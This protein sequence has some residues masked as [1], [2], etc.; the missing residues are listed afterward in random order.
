[1]TKRSTSEINGIDVDDWHKLKVELIKTLMYRSCCFTNWEN[2]TGSVRLQSYI[3]A[4]V[5]YIANGHMEW[6]DKQYWKT[7]LE[8]SSREEILTGEIKRL[9]H[10]WD[11]KEFRSTSTFKDVTL[12]PETIRLAEKLIIDDTLGQESYWEFLDKNIKKLTD[13]T[14][15]GFLRVSYAGQYTWDYQEKRLFEMLALKSGS[16]RRA[17]E[18]LQSLHCDEKCNAC[19][20]CELAKN[21]IDVVFS[22]DYCPHCKGHLCD[23]YDPRDSNLPPNPDEKPQKIKGLFHKLPNWE[24]KGN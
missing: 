24:K 23:T 19:P 14:S 7:A 9:L 17:E 12:T 8:Q 2:G 16:K 11:W 20:R 22:Y 15:L 21:A 3:W 10:E 6:W 5:Q 1:M 13:K 4:F 18:Y